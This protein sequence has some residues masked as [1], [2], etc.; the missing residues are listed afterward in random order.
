MLERY[1]SGVIRDREPLLGE[2]GVS[3]TKQQV[4]ETRWFFLGLIQLQVFRLL[5]SFFRFTGTFNQYLALRSAATCCFFVSEIVMLA[6][7]CRSMNHALKSV[8]ERE[9]LQE[10]Y[11]ASRYL[12]PLVNLRSFNKDSTASVISQKSKNRSSLN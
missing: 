11:D 7:L 3:S 9:K 4:V 5:N 12:S 2:Q 10:K 8:L 6:C 1:Y